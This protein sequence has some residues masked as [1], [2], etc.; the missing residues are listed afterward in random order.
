M[1]IDVP[2]D[3]F[4]DIGLLVDDLYADAEKRWREDGQP[5]NHFFHAVA[6]VADWLQ[7]NQPKPFQPRTV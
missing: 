2:S 6:R 3:V 4:D 5:K 1:T 7:A